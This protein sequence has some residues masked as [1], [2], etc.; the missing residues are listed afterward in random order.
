MID[1]ESA[2]SEILARLPRR[3]AWR[4]GTF[5]VVYDFTRSESPLRPIDANDLNGSLPDPA[6]KNL[7]V[8]GEHSVDGGASPFITI[9]SLS[10]KVVG[11]D[12]E[13]DGTGVFLLNS[14]LETFIATVRHLNEA[15]SSGATPS[16]LTQTLQAVEPEFQN[17]EWRDLAKYFG[18]RPE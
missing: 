17:S 7:L 3:C 5:A 16:S 9:D 18:G 10:G 15:L 1:S 2:R 14:A 6:W 12:P 4:V 11:V 13:R 8:I